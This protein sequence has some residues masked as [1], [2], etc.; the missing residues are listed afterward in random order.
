MHDYIC[1]MLYVCYA[2][3]NVTLADVAQLVGASHKL[4]AYA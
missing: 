3:Q 1:L 2:S 4:K